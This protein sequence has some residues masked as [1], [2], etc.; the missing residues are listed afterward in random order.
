VFKADRRKASKSECTHVCVRERERERECVCVCVCVCVSLLSWF[1]LARLLGNIRHPVVD[2]L[3][4]KDVDVGIDAAQI[5]EDDVAEEVGAL[6]WQHAVIGWE[7]IG[8]VGRDPGQ[9]VSVCV[10]FVFEVRVES[11]PCALR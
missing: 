7:Q 4:A 11:P 10:Q 3:R 5:V 1:A 9:D 8:V 2:R 6:D